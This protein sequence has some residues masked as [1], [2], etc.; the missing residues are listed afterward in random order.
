[1]E[2]HHPLG[3]FLQI[4]NVSYVSPFFPLPSRVVL[5]GY[6]MVVYLRAATAVESHCKALNWLSVEK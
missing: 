2:Q 6:Y 4:H 1:M 3:F 5:V